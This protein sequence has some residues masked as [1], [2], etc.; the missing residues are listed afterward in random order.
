MKSANLTFR[1]SMFGERHQRAPDR[2]TTT[3]NG[4]ERE[5][6]RESFTNW[7][8][9]RR[10]KKKKINQAKLYVICILWSVNSKERSDYEWQ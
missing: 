3:E 8:L 9:Q 7:Q 2:A 6:E 10:C 4:Q 5:R 1:M